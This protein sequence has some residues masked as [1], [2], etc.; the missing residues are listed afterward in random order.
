MRIPPSL[1]K[2]KWGAIEKEKKRIVARAPSIAMPI[3]QRKRLEKT[4]A[5]KMMLPMIRAIRRVRAKRKNGILETKENMV[6]SNREILDQPENPHPLLQIDFKNEL[7][8]RRRIRKSLQGLRDSLANYS[9]LDHPD[10]LSSLKTL[11]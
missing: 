2:K 8:N 3:P 9:E 1:S 10:L 4:G 6:A 5:K 11:G 7:T